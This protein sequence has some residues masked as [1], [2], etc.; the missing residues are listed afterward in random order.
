VP[1]VVVGEARK[2]A[3]RETRRE[4]AMA[5]YM[6]LIYGDEAAASNMSDAQMKEVGDAYEV[7]TQSIKSSGNYVDGDPFLATDTATNVRVRD[8]KTETGKGP[9][10]ATK[11]QLTAYYTGRSRQPR[12]G[13][14]DGLAHPRCELGHHRGPAPSG[15]S[16]DEVLREG[17]GHRLPGTFETSTENAADRTSRPGVRTSFERTTEKGDVSPMTVSQAVGVCAWR[18]CSSVRSW[19]PLRRSDHAGEIRPTDRPSAS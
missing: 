13:R 17:P 15:S 4:R 9:A 11:E 16:T 12:A 10:D 6:L 1:F 3:A 7:F 8:G 18:C 14:R 5:K 2:H 19:R